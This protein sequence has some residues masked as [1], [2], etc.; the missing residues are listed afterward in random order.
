MDGRRPST[1]PDALALRGVAGPLEHNGRITV[2]EVERGVRQGERRAL[3]VAELE[4]GFILT[5]QSHP[6]TPAAAVDFDG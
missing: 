2:D 4:A 6:T 3:M 1:E 5:C